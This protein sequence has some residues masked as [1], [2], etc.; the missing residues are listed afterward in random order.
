MTRWLKHKRTST[1]DLLQAQSSYAVKRCIK[2]W[3][4]RAA[5]TIAARAAYDKFQMKRDLMYKRSV[6]RELMLKHHRDKA[7][8][9]RLSNAAK[10]F[11]SRNL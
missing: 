5:V 2:K 4:A 1:S 6:F 9:L 10:K 11:D 7:L 8:V 3:R